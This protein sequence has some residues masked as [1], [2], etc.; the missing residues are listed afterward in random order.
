MTLIYPE[1][2]G[3]SCRL[4]QEAPAAVTQDAGGLRVL[5]GSEVF[6]DYMRGAKDHIICIWCLQYIQYVV[7]DIW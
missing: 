4:R 1:A 5:P 2:A 3:W 7:Y 6:K